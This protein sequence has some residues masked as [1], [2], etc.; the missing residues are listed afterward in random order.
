MFAKRTR[1]VHRPEPARPVVDDAE[2]ASAMA[3]LADAFVAGVAAEGQLLAYAPEDVYALD[4]VVDRYLATLP[5]YDARRGYAFSLGAYLGEL[6]IRVCGGHWTRD[7]ATGQPGVLLSSG[8]M[9]LPMDETARRLEV[10]MSHG[11]V[12]F[13]EAC[14]D[15]R[16][17]DRQPTAV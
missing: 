1:P 17:V 6:V 2:V 10:G 16:R 9:S 3:R 11:L 14:A 12:A 8:R 13:V 5:G 4:S 7:E 15:G